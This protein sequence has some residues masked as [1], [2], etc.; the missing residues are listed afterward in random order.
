M[1]D[2]FDAFEKCANSGDAESARYLGIMYMRGKG[3]SKNA[4]EAIRWFEYAANQGD[5]L[6]EKNLASLLKNCEIVTFL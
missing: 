4:D 3:V 2:A 1:S 5:T 6:A